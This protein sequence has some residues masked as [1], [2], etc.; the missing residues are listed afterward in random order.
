AEELD[1]AMGRIT[2]VTADTART[3]D[4]STTSRSHS[5]IESGTA[6]RL[7]AA[8]AR[9]LLLAKASAQLGVPVDQL[10]VADGVISSGAGGKDV[11]YWSL[12][13][14]ETL[15][16]VVSGQA[17]T[18]AP[19]SFRYVGK[20]IP[21]LDIPGKLTGAPSFVQ[22]LRLPGMLHARIVRP[23]SDRADIAL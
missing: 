15:H 3:P 14:G 11:T 10:S 8:E 13:E 12:V 7:A 1:V 21:R 2:V 9:M 6:L 19:G 16:R 22:D 20:S 23:P 4:E 5:I 17:R 18:K